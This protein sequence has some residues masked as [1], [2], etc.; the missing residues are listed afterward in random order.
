MWYVENGPRCNLPEPVSLYVYVYV[1]FR[2]CNLGTRKPR[3][4]ARFQTSK[5]GYVCG[6]KPGFYGF[7]L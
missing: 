4:P 3:L 6:E 2:E 5:P 1:G 7:N